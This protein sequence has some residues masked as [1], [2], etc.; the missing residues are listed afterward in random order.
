MVTLSVIM[1]TLSLILVKQTMPRLV[2][3]LASIDGHLGLQR[4]RVSIDVLH[5][6]IILLISLHVLSII[7]HID[8]NGTWVHLLWVIIFTITLY[9]FKLPD[10]LRDRE[11]ELRA[12]VEAPDIEHRP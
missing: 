7:M 8:D 5:A 4:L 12:R 3:D 10:K 11:T 9:W 1:F 6:C 2:C